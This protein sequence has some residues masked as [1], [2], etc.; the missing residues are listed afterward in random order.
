MNR[1]LRLPWA[2]SRWRAAA[3]TARTSLTPA[4]VADSCSKWE[5][6]ARATMCASEVL[7]VPAGPHRITERSSSASISARRALPAPSTWACPT[8]SSRVRG[9]IR[10]AKGA[11]LPA[12]SP[13]LASN[14]SMVG[15][16]Y[17]LPG[18][19]PSAAQSAEQRPAPRRQPVADLQALGQPELLELAHVGLEG[20]APAAEPAGQVG[21]ARPGPLAEQAQHLQRPRAVAAGPVQ[22]VQARGELRPLAVGQVVGAAQRLPRVGPGQVE[23]DPVD[24]AVAAAVEEAEQL[25]AAGGA[26]QAG[27]PLADGGRVDQLDGVDGQHPRRGAVAPAGPGLRPPPAPERQRHRAVGQPGPQS[28]LEQHPRPITQGERGAAA[29]HGAVAI[30]RLHL[31]ATE[32]VGSRPGR[33]RYPSVPGA[34]HAREYGPLRRSVGA[35]EKPATNTVGRCRQRIQPP[36]RRPGNRRWVLPNHDLRPAP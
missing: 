25:G 2:P 10:A 35:N 21:G 31:L 9:R 32:Q 16:S 7:P 28:P 11:W 33:F 27:L 6:V 8:N 12:S 22:A 1:M 20:G 19:P 29:L 14:R 23:G 34:F 26:G 24:G 13:A 36:P 4:L 17:C 18:T 30:R 15:P 5:R 3:S